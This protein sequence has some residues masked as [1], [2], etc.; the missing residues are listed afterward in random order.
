MGLRGYPRSFTH[1]TEVKPDS[2]LKGG[3]MA[4]TLT[5]RERYRTHTQDLDWTE[6]QA[7]V[8]VA[9]WERVASAVTAGGLIAAALFRRSWSGRAMGLLGAALLHRGVTGHCAVYHALGAN[10]NDL[11]RR[12]VRTGRAVKL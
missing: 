4:A 7:S 1:A 12:K 6:E 5:G 8:N 9:D 10:T 2:S 3:H 11:G